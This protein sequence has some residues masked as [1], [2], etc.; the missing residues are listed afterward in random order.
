MNTD[1]IP[2]N[3]WGYLAGALVWCFDH[4][5]GVAAFV[6]FVLQAVYQVYRIKK[7]KQEC[8]AKED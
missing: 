5:S 6:L 3:L 7:V 1:N 4:W 8:T 2:L